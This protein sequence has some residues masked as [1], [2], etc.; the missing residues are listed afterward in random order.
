MEPRSNIFFDPDEHPEDTLKSF[1]EFISVFSLRYE[2]QYPDPPK[3]SLESA[4]QRWKIANTTD[5][6]QTP[7]PS[8]DQYDSICAEW[9]EKDKVKKLLGMF[10]SHKLYEDWC[11]AEPNENVRLNANW[12][13][14]VEAIKAYYRP[15]ENQTLKHFH[16]RTVNQ[17]PEESFPRFCSRVEAEAKHCR[18][19][20]DYQNCN[21]EET[22]IRDQILIGTTNS[23]VRDEALKQS[24]GLSELRTEGMKM[25]S[26]ARSGAQISN[27]QILNKVGKV[28]FQN[29]KTNQVPIT[30]YNC[31]NKVSGN[32]SK[33]KLQCP[34]KSH[35]CN[36]CQKKGHY[37]KVCR[38]KSVNLMTTKESGPMNTEAK[39]DEVIDEDLY[40]V[41]LFRIRTSTDKSKPQ[42]K[43]CKTSDFTVQSC[44]K[45][46]P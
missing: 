46:P 6:K 9:K 3:V 37:E 34:A 26:A 2:A 29:K 31:G 5:V 38:N 42:L 11:I 23:D 39:E 45:Q 16:F 28:K 40:S 1:E 27:E 17:L 32:I 19:K 35:T 4:I 44:G 21:A 7:T 41:N 15:T 13:E 10:S 8:I 24:W 12:T 20:C 30:C 43:K 22:A 14:F 18:F 25:E 36:K 33:H